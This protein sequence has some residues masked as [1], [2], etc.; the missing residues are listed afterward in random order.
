MC[1][2]KKNWS[3]CKGH[4]PWFQIDY[5]VLQPLRDYLK[6]LLQ[7]VW[8]VV[9]MLCCCTFLFKK[10][11]ISKESPKARPVFLILWNGD[12][13]T[14]AGQCNGKCSLQYVP[15]YCKFLGELGFG[16]IQIHNISSQSCL[17]D[18]L[19]VV[20]AA[21]PYEFNFVLPI[22]VCQNFTKSNQQPK[23]FLIRSVYYS[24]K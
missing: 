10:T 6:K 24:L 18:Q 7:P 1:V 17:L 11:N 8:L 19:S 3:T 2:Y 20:E 21:W 12:Q 13:I 9:V 16:P 14:A 15:D 5:F 22:N 4:L 23:S